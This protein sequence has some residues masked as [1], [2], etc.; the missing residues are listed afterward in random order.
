M[1]GLGIGKEYGLEEGLGEMKTEWE[2][3]QFEMKE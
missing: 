1:E 3:I 2:K